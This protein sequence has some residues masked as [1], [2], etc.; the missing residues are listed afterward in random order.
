MLYNDHLYGLSK[1]I[2]WITGHVEELI[3]LIIT[4][5]QNVVTCFKMN[6]D[7]HTKLVNFIKDL[8]RFKKLSKEFM[9]IQFIY[10]NVPMMI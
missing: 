6:K 1:G 3:I 8:D 10:Q 4:L 2:A 7:H 9:D 5:N